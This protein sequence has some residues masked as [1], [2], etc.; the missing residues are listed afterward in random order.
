M[1]DFLLE[2][3]AK[4][5]FTTVGASRAALRLP[6]SVSGPFSPCHWLVLAAVLG[7]L[8]GLHAL[9]LTAVQALTV[10]CNSFRH[11]RPSQD[12]SSCACLLTFCSTSCRMFVL[13]F[14]L[15]P[16]FGLRSYSF[17]LAPPCRVLVSPSMNWTRR[18]Q[19]HNAEAE[20]DSSCPGEPA[21]L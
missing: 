15:L 9:C 18:A 11:W 17:A 7:L 19:Q 21:G 12:P 8:L 10:L 13:S 4:A 20:I 16:P 3:G 6:G 2:E 14:I 1:C 5:I